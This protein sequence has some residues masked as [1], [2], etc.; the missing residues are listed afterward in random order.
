[1]WNK[2]IDFNPAASAHSGSVRAHPQSALFNSHIVNVGSL[3]GQFGKV[4]ANCALFQGVF[5]CVCVEAFVA[6]FS[7]PQGGPGFG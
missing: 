6:P 1:M 5:A 2:D 4:L 7:S 3:M